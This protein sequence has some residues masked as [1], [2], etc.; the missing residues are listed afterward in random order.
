MLRINFA[1]R[2]FLNQPRGPPCLCH[3]KRLPRKSPLYGGELRL[4]PPPNPQ[5][6]NPPQCIYKFSK[7][8]NMQIIHDGNFLIC[9]GYSLLGPPT[10]PHRSRLPLGA[11]S[12]HLC[13]LAKPTRAQ[14][15]LHPTEKYQKRPT[16]HMQCPSEPPTLPSAANSQIT[17]VYECKFAA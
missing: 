3:L 5:H 9:F 12:A 15:S 13:Y 6:S 8:P 17:S 10:L 14:F 16:Q 2:H 7:L 4:R 11:R 1:T